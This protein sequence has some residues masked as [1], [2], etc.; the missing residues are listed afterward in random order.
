MATFP[1]NLRTDV[2]LSAR[3]TTSEYIDMV[4][5]AFVTGAA[6]SITARKEREINIQRT[7]N[8]QT[9]Y[10]YLT[11]VGMTTTIDLDDTAL[12]TVPCSSV[13]GAVDSSVSIYDGASEITASNAN[14]DLTA[15]VRARYRINGSITIEP[16]SSNTSP[17]FV[18]ATIEIWNGTVWTDYAFKIN[19]TQEYDGKGTY[20]SIAAFEFDMNAGDKVR[21]AAKGGAVVPGC[22]VQQAYLSMAIVP[23]GVVV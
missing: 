19:A 12:A 11:R 6:D 5:S 13:A 16:P 7:I 10:A 17:L 22:I 20:L 4:D 15:V 21:M 1:L 8:D 18:S 9:A 23:N 2:T 3:Q 14:Q